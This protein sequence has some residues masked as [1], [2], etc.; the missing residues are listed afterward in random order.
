MKK[1]E[2]DFKITNV[3]AKGRII[4]EINNRPAASELLRLLGWSEENLNEDTWFKTNYYFPLSFQLNDNQK[5]L[6][7]RV[8]V[9]VFGESLITTIKSNKSK[10]SILTIDGKGL[11]QAVKENLQSFPNNPEFGLIASCTT[12]LET[13]ED[14]SY[15]VNEYLNEYFDKKPFIEVYVG[16]ESTYSPHKGL[17]FMN[18]SFNTAIFWDGA[19]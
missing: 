6:C 17:V 16:G 9:G 3:G 5:I 19:N 2:V 12:R 10:S 8:I 1:T 15:Q 13:L 18:M 11:L 4:K 14:Y 7:P